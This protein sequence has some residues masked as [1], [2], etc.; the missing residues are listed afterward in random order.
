MKTLA[1]MIKQLAAMVDTD[2]LTEWE[3][4]FVTNID[5]RTL[6][7]DST[8]TQSLSSK[9]VDVIDRLY[10]KHFGDGS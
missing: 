6:N 7:G 3:N 8:R 1:S 10:R 2:D 4:E 5:Q 9:Q